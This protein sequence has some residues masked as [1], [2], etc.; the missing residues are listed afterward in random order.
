MY[1]FEEMY[2]NYKYT[3]NLKV[4]CLEKLKEANPN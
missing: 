4:K 3:E 2:L 1:C